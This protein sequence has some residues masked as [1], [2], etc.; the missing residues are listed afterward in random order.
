MTV[1]LAKF[2]PQSYY[3]GAMVMGTFQ[4]IDGI[5]ALV[6]YR[7]SLTTAF[8][9]LEILWFVASLVVL[10]VFQL[11]RFSLLVPLLF[12]CYFVFSYMYGSLL[13]ASSVTNELVLPLG[14]VITYILFAMTYVYSSCQAYLHASNSM[15]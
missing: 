12:I 15:H 8:S 2:K 4:I 10:L 11:R 9:L 5:L 1:L 6:E 7:S 14:Y 13:L 3:G